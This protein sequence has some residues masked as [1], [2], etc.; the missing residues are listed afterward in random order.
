MRLLTL[1]LCL[2]MATAAMAK[3]T[4]VAIVDG[5]KLLQAYPGVQKALKKIEAVTEKRNKELA[6]DADELKT[7]QKE[8]QEA[9]AD[10][11][12]KLQKTFDKK[13][14]AFQEK[15]D[16]MQAELDAQKRELLAKAS[17]EIKALISKV[18][19]DHEVDLVMD[20]EKAFYEADGIDLTEEVL[21]SYPSK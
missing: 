11:K 18:A 6:G 9:D 21:K 10:D 2:S 20:S 17:N 15:K 7:L 16:K 8:F 13:A 3:D 14:K 1:L 12:A 4:K 19:K 5:Q